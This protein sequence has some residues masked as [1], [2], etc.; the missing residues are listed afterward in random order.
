MTKRRKR[1]PDDSKKSLVKS[2]HELSCQLA[3]VPDGSRVPT[4]SRSGRQFMT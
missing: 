4:M 3:G 2:L 1:K